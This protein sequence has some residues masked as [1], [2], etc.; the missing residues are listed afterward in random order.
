MRRLLVSVF[1]ALALVAPAT[2]AAA[3]DG[4]P[5]GVSMCPYGY[6]GVVLWHYD[7]TSGYTYVWACLP[8]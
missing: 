3:S 5:V 4:P 7:G 6:Y 1:A 8:R 2:G